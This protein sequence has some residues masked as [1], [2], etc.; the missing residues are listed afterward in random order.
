MGSTPK[1]SAR[2]EKWVALLGRRDTPTDGVEDYCTFLGEALEQHGVRLQ[3]VRVRWSE[4]RWFRALRHLW[5]ESSG[6]RNGWV[7]LQYTA[8]GWSRR[9]FP[10]GALAALTIL[11]RRGLRTAVVFHEPFRQGGPRWIDHLRG[12]CQDWVV[13]KLYSG[14][15]KAIFADPL[16]TIPW[17][18]RNESKAAF[19]PIGANIPARQRES[20][21][22]S[23]GNAK[24]IAIFC[25]SDPPNRERELA[26]IVRAVKCATESGLNARVVF[27]GRGTSEASDDIKRAFHSVPV[28]VSDLGL[29]PAN[30]VSRILSEADAMLCVRGPLYPR[31]GSA[32]AAIACGLPIIAY[33]GAAEGTPL[34]EAGVELVPHA[35]REALGI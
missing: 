15:T 14:S 32:I 8:M 24:T 6:W 33:A 1:A 19:I 16:E 2:T 3:N 18:P 31:R 30:E 7:L 21:S 28:E 27:M 4:E 35:D 11:R 29:Q 13:C 26:E 23:N 22:P 12:V 25:L 9:G 20:I 5:R 34:A 17:L 10:F